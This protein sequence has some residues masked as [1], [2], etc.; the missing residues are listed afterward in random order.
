[1]KRIVIEVDDRFVTK[2]G[3]FFFGAI[4]NDKDELQFII[5]PAPACLPGFEYVTNPNKD[6]PPVFVIK[7]DTSEKQKKIETEE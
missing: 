2:Y 6:E 1:M 4:P 5:P 3:F 7:E